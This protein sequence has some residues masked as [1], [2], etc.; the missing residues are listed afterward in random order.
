MVHR[1]CVFNYSCVENIS[2]GTADAIG[3]VT[4]QLSNT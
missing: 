2:S 1:K 3:N 4:K